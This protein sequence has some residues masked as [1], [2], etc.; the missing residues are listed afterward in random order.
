[1]TVPKF[2]MALLFLLLPVQTAHGHALEPGFLDLKQQSETVWRVFWRVPD[3]QGA[4][5]TITVALPETCAQS[6]MPQ[7]VFDGAAWIAAW[8][9]TCP[10]G[11]SG[12]PISIPGLDRQQTDVLVRLQRVEGST[13]THRLTSKVTAFHV[14]EQVSGFSMV[15]SYFGL[16]FEHILAGWDHLLF[17]FALLILIKDLR[18]LVFAITAFTVAHSITLALAALG[19]ITVPGPPV[20]AIIA[21]SIVFL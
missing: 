3:V 5:M 18:R 12:S 7:Q 19:H 8:R 15:F 11:L 1:M 13:E 17:V 6:Q 9:V 14:P 2:L 16:G 4:P 21:L 10:T 20:E